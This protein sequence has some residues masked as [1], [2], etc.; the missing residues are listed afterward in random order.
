MAMFIQMFVNHQA[1]L[2]VRVLENGNQE[3]VL[4]DDAGQEIV[5][6][7]ERK[8]GFYICQGSCRITNRK[9]VDL[10]RK[11]V[12]SFKGSAVVHRIYAAY[13]MI[14]EYERGTVVKIMESKNGNEKVIYE[15]KDTVGQLEQLFQ[16]D[17]VERE[18]SRIKL[19]I[20]QLL[21]LRND[22]QDEAVREHIDDRLQKLTH[23]LFVLEA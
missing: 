15:Y 6:S 11:A 10:M 19:T 1:S 22:L 4:P 17:A 9:L 12:S 13:T 2:Q 23:E 16:N 18:I 20:N 8:L 21:D 14:Y 3:V 7:F 5:L